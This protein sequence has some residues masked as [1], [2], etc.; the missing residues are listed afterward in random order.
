MNM[1]F[2]KNPTC[3][4]FEVTETS[5]QTIY[6]KSTDRKL[7]KLTMDLRQLEKKRWGDNRKLSRLK[8]FDK[9]DKKVFTSHLKSCFPVDK[10]FFVPL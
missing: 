7:Q 6:K 4:N 1:N 3:F 9:T 10:T 2:I 8:A 5:H